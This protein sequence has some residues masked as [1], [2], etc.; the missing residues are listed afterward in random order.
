MLGK[1]TIDLTGMVF[2]RLTVVSYSHK[3]SLRKVYWNCLC[4]CGNSCIARGDSLKNKSIRSCGCLLKDTLFKDLTGKKFS[5]LKVIE[6]AGKRGTPR[7]YWKCLCDC[8][9][10]SYV[11]SGSLIRGKTRSCGCLQKEYLN[12]N[13]DV[14]GSKYKISYN[15]KSSKFLCQKHSGQ[16]VKFG[17][18]QKRTMMDKNNIIIKNNYAEIE[19]Y[20]RNCDI[21]GYSKI[22]I[23]DIEKVKEYKW[24]TN[25]TGYVSS[26]HKYGK[27]LMLN[28]FIVDC[29][30]LSVV[31]DH[32][33]H[34]KLDNRKENL[35]ICTQQQNV[36][37]S[38][39]SKLNTSGFKGVHFS[40]NTNKWCSRISFKG[41]RIVLGYYKDIKDAIKVR[42]EAE[43]K[44]FG[45]YAYKD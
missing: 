9:N 22:D 24:G 12:H 14:C 30:D 16:M 11:D 19:L 36:M 6:C 23:E 21:V 3:D 25:N 28:R 32:I 43:E 13:C 7:Y 41:G 35:R 26:T 44:Y 18:I 31:V 1:R 39:I 45:E 10:I 4:S 37:N 5:K 29:T 42:K 17:S 27:K 15:R 38:S 20:N 2:E 40:K 34:D 33:N 8:G